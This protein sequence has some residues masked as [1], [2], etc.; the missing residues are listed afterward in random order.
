MMAEVD[1]SGQVLAELV[2]DD[3]E[4]RRHAAKTAGAN[5][6]A[7]RRAH[8]VCHRLRWVLRHDS[9]EPARE[10]AAWALGR[11]SDPE[12][13]TDLT[14]QLRDP[15]R[16][17]RC[18][19]AQ[20]LGEIGDLK[21]VEPLLSLLETDAD[22]ICRTFVIDALGQ[23]RNAPGARAALERLAADPAVPH[24][25]RLHARQAL[26]G[27]RLRNKP[28]SDGVPGQLQIA[29]MDED[30]TPT[31]CP[32]AIPGTPVSWQVVTTRRPRRNREIAEGTKRLRRHICQVCGL[33][34]FE[35]AGGLYAQAHHVT[36]LAD[37]G[38]DSPNNLLV[39]CPTCHAMLH[40]AKAVR[41]GYA[42]GETRPQTVEING[43]TFTLTW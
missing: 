33:P 34:G 7:I 23:L 14:A 24:A 13:V 8:L 18:Y 42:A 38:T 11:L 40:Y 1:I 19:A 10:W 29:G 37:G 30:L 26:S 6:T 35:T 20:A 43:R 36:A 22:D 25:M 28:A 3:P 41:Y 17:L 2:S 16:D 27:I 4:I 39:V 32:R 12:A 21:A 15:N 5:A 31:E 9:W